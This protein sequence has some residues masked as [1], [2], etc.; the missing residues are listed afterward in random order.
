MNLAFN[1]QDD[2]D[3]KTQT[4]LSIQRVDKFYDKNFDGFGSY[5]EDKGIHNLS[6][7]ES[8]I[9]EDPANEINEVARLRGAIS[10]MQKIKDFK[11]DYT[12]P[13]YKV[14][15]SNYMEIQESL[16]K[17]A[18][19]QDT[20]V[21]LVL[22][23][24]EDGTGTVQ[25]SSELVGASPNVMKL[26]YVTQWKE[27]LVE[28]YEGNESLIKIGNIA[29]LDSSK[30]FPALASALS[31][32][33]FTEVNNIGLMADTGFSQSDLKDPDILMKASVIDYSDAME[34]LSYVSRNMHSSNRPDVNLS[35]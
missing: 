11:E 6:D 25:V 26:P 14:K 27:Q 32:F 30:I 35:L 16:S 2:L 8:F 9:K 33:T 7:Y 24:N 13:S 3:K 28:D 34:L 17:E 19:R 31:E 12:L 18:F 23:H 21:S 20:G 5:L 22:C 4:F 29:L 10:T 1:L 15:A